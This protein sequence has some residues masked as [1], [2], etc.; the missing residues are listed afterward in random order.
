MNVFLAYSYFEVNITLTL[1]QK[2]RMPPRVSE[3]FLVSRSNTRS[4]VVA[5]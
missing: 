2:T 5:L 3:E 1:R 4:A